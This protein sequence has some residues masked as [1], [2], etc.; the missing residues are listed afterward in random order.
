MCDNKQRNPHDARVLC[1]FQLLGHSKRCVMVFVP[2]G[3]HMMS[4]H[5]YNKNFA[6]II[7]GIYKTR[8]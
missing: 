8:K 6:I 2:T 4:W 1:V 7:L 5:G 3:R